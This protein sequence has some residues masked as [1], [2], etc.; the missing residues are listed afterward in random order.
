MLG[1]IPAARQAIIDRIAARA[2]RAGR[3]GLPASPERLVRCF[4][5]GVSEL[6]L[7]QRKPEDLAGAALAQF[8]LGRQRRA[9]R[10][11]VR[12]F[13]PDPRRDGFSSSHTVIMVVTDDMPFL[14]DSLG[15]VCTE[16]RARRAPARAPGLLGDARRRRAPARGPLDDSAASGTRPNRGS[17][18]RSTGEPD[19]K[20]LVELERRI[21]STLDDVACATDDWRRMRERMA[22][23]RRRAALGRPPVPRTERRL[24]ESKQL[25]EWMEDN[26]FVFLGYREYRLERGAQRDR[27]VPVAKAG[28]ASCARPARR[29]SGPIHAA[30]ARSAPSRARPSR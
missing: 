17:A 14:V 8:R 25:L 2:R 10:S 3:K 29:G 24:R 23:A 11:L 16:A 5:H 15:M 18:S 12:V 28:S 7:V 27:L 21:R 9:R 26:H 30:A 19:P 6:D 22:N 1:R 20:R 4:Y 13:N